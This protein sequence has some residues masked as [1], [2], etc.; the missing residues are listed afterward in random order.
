M[1]DVDLSGSFQLVWLAQGWTLVDSGISCDLSRQF[2][3]M[4]TLQTIPMLERRVWEK[5]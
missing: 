5:P 3:S 2:P 1:F 4:T